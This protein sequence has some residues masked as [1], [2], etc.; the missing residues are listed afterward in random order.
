MKTGV[1]EDR[2][3]NLNCGDS[4]TRFFYYGACSNSITIGTKQ[5]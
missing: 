5:G 4:F 2:M 3:L 1:G